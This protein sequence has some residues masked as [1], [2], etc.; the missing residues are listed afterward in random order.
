[1][2]L[3]VVTG[4]VCLVTAITLGVVLSR[5]GGGPDDGCNYTDFRLRPYAAPTR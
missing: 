1:M 4:V 5:K 3:G 2:I